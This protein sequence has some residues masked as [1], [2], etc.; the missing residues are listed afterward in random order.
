MT[1]MRPGLRRGVHGTLCVVVACLGV[2]L[3]ACEEKPRLEQPPPPERS[4]SAAEKPTGQVAPTPQ[5]DGAQALIAR[6]KPIFGVLP[7]AAVRSD[8]PLTDAKIALGRQLYFETRLSKA[9]DLS[10]NSCHDLAKYGVDVRTPG[11]KTS[12]GHKGALGDR[13]APTVYNAA[14]HIAQFWDGRAK[15]VEEQ[16]KG[17]ILN[18]VE[19]AMA[20]EAAVLKVLAS[21]DGYQKMFA[22]AFPDDKQP[23]TYDNLGLAI[24]A[25]ERKLTTKGRFDAFLGGDASALSE[26]EQRGLGL[27]LDAGCTACHAGPA[28]GGQMYQKLG[29]LKPYPTQDPGRSKVTGNEA[30]KFFFKVPSLRNIAETAPYLHDGSIATLEQMVRIMAEHQTAKGKLSEAET[31]DLVAFLKS[32]TGDLPAS[33]YIAPPPA[34]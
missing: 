26:Q 31:A 3:A 33:S 10:C 11:A 21:I 12:S 7:A 27:F 8:N 16:A 25:F 24:G 4:S 32:L 20:D 18:P 13:N 22:A 29:L 15:D 17:P 14:L 34:I 30:E 28:L 5:K 9:G 19:M 2:S 6:A 23:L 1:T